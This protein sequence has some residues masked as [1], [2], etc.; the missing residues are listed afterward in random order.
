MI[1]YTQ[2][3]VISELNTLYTGPRTRVRHLTEQRYYL[4]AVLYYKF[5]MI[6]SDIFDLTDLSNRSTINHA[7]RMGVLLYRSKDP[8]FIRNV[9]HLI[10][11]FPYDFPDYDVEIINRPHVNDV[12]FAV[13]PKTMELLKKYMNRKGFETVGQSAKHIVTNMLRLWEE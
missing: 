1:N 5:K 7:K 9:K 12:K 13:T 2:A 6:E 11:K 4:I 3:Q 10:K 8:I